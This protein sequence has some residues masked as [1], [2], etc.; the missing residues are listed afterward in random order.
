MGSMKYDSIRNQL[1]ELMGANRNGDRAD[2]IISVRGHFA[3]SQVDV[4][5]AAMRKENMNN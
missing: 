1:D 2:S 5:G 3:G 4:G